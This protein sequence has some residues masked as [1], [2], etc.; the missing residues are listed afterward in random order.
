MSIEDTFG[1]EF[2]ENEPYFNTVGELQQFVINNI[3]LSSL[4]TAI[5][6]IPKN[7]SEGFISN[8]EYKK[9]QLNYPYA[10]KL[11]GFI[12]KKSYSHEQILLHLEEIK[13]L[14][15]NEIAIKNKVIELIQ[16][17]IGKQPVKETDHFI[18]NLGFD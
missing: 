16:Q 18:E 12:K 8:K 11:T 2:P 13:S 15:H 5:A 1:L 10:P 4:K 7:N 6:S 9:F 14:E 17:I 3:N